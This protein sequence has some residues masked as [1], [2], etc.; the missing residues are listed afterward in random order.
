MDLD[1]RKIVGEYLMCNIKTDIND[2][3]TCEMQCYSEST[4]DGYDVYVLKYTKDEMCIVENVYYYEHDIAEQIM[5]SIDENKIDSIYIDEDLY[6][7]IYL[8]DAFEEYFNEHVD[9]IIFD[10]PELF[11]DEEKEFIREEYEIEV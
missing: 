8:E 9:E 10:N 11:S 7:E 2:F 4:A 1:F 3:D 5:Y 6:D